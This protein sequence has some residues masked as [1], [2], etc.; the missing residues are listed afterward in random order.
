VKLGPR[1]TNTEVKAALCM[2]KASGQEADILESE[3]Q[4]VQIYYGWQLAVTPETLIA[5]NACQ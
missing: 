5:T 3:Y 4:I 2:L 1:A